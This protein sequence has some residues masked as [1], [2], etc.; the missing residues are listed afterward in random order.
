MTYIRGPLKGLRV[1]MWGSIRSEMCSVTL[2]GF[3]GVSNG[4][5]LKF[6]LEVKCDQTEWSKMTIL[7]IL[8]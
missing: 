1:C 7:V 4:V 2:N 3:K 8:V 5:D 6:A